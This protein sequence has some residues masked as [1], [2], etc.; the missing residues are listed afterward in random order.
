MTRLSP[1]ITRNGLIDCLGRLAITHAVT[2]KPNHKGERATEEFL[3]SAF[4]VFDREVNHSL[5]GPR[6]HDP[7]KRHLRTEA[8]GI[9]EGLPFAGH[10]HAGFRVVPE[11]WADFERLFQ[12]LTPSLNLN[13]VRANPWVARIVGGT[14]VVERITD[15][16][17]WLT[18]CT[19][20]FGSIDASDRI[21]F[22][23]P[24][25]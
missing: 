20:D 24:V 18:Y 13:P 15:A 16:H 3:R 5:L 12:P 2:L 23:P 22:L 9:I 6:F 14:S 11:R 19:K 25:A 10:I 4:N 1:R 17:G 8:W 7:K 21:M